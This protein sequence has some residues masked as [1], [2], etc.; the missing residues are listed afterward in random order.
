MKAGKRFSKTPIVYYPHRKG[1]LLFSVLYAPDM[2]GLTVGQ[3]LMGEVAEGH[4]AS[5]GNLLVR[6]SF[7]Q[8]A[9]D[10]G[11]VQVSIESPPSP[12]TATM[13]EQDQNE[14]DGTS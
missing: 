2:V 7:N 8:N 5:I 6:K 10:F 11:C 12:C 4:D 3:P 14:S 1:M 9:S 13:L